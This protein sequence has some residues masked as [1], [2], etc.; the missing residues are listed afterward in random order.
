MPT[1][2][3]AAYWT[4]GEPSGGEEGVGTVKVPVTDLKVP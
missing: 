3:V 2:A 4:S 1:Q